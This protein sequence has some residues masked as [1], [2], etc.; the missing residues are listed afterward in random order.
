[1]KNIFIKKIAIVLI[2]ACLIL[3]LFSMNLVK[4]SAILDPA[5]KLDVY[6]IAGQSNAAGTTYYMRDVRDYAFGVDYVVNLSDRSLKSEYDAGYSNVYYCGYSGV[7]TSK[8]GGVSHSITVTKSGLGISPLHIGPE[9]G[10]AKELQKKYANSNND[11]LIIKYAVGASSL[12]GKAGCS[13]GNWCPPSKV[14]TSTIHGE[15]LYY[16]MVGHAE[17]GYTD[18]AIYQYLTDVI[19]SSIYIDG[20]YNGI[21]FKGLVWL[22]GEAESSS[23]S[24]A[25][26]YGEYLMALINDFRADAV[27]LANKFSC[28]KDV[29]VTSKVDLPFVVS[30]I[31]PTFGGAQW[32]EETGSNNPYINIIIKRERRV[33]ELMKNVVT[34]DTTD[35][36]IV[37]ESSMFYSLSEGSYSMDKWHYNADDIIEIGEKAGAFFTSGH[38]DKKTD[39][40]N[41]S[42]VGCSASVNETESTI[43]LGLVPL[44][45]VGI[46]IPLKRE[47]LR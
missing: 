9:L 14:A 7:S 33:A 30:E 29:D 20:G 31:A 34:I 43:V 24:R 13:W 25:K 37:K 21:V 40:N 5:K 3:P 1:M 35:Y 47:K 28:D 10:M 6:F 39:T 19:N 18:G 2:C 23:E 4:V 16:N 36:V 32:F 8:Q 38:F 15:N 26:A 22:Q 11:A 41:T 27:E 42:K 44:I 46:L 45:L 12:D 17:N